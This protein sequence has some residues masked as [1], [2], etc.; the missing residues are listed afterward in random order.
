[1]HEASNVFGYLDIEG[2]KVFDVLESEFSGSCFGC[3][4]SNTFSLHP[5][6]GNP[7]SKN[8]VQCHQKMNCSIQGLQFHKIKAVRATPVNVEVKKVKKPKDPMMMGVRVGF[9][10]PENG[11]CKH[12]KRSFRW[13]RFPCCGRIFPC[14]KCHDENSKDKHEIIVRTENFIFFSFLKLF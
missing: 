1:M 2:C 14:D 4:T 13:M 9:P 12:Y 3:S 8:C 7:V 10:L 6:V 11:A 5:M